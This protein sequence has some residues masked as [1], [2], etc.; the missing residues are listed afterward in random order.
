MAAGDSLNDASPIQTEIGVRTKSENKRRSAMDIPVANMKP[1]PELAA[2]GVQVQLVESSLTSVKTTQDFIKV[3]GTRECK[4]STP[5]ETRIRRLSMRSETT[6][7]AAML[8]F[9]CMFA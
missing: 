4:E 6:H 1:R 3:A 5:T 8:L 2:V 7:N 9:Y